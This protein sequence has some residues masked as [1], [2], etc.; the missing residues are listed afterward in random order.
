MTV[1]SSLS[2]ARNRP[3][4][5]GTDPYDDIEPALAELAALAPDSREHARLREELQHRCLPL[6]DHIARRYTGRGETYDDLYQVA[7]LGMVNAIDRFDSTRETPFLAFAVP[8][9]MGE[10]R[11]Y[12]RDFGWSVRVP[13]RTKEVE[14]ALGPTVEALTQRLSR[15]PTAVEIAL[16]LDIDLTEVTQAMLA[17]N[18]YS[19]DSLDTPAYDQA[20]ESIADTIGTDDPGYQL[21]EQALTIAPLLNDLPARERTVLHLRFFRGYTQ[22]QIATQLGLSQMHV[23]R[24]L[25]RTLTALRD[26]ALP[27]D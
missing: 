12:F 22:N 27:D 11:R 14:L 16:E 6:A 20:P 2:P 17:A 7:C 5:R 25:T 24:I 21:T 8:T 13:R 18:A 23:S 26:R 9:I 15:M 19:S 4:R 10:V 1:Q 3:A